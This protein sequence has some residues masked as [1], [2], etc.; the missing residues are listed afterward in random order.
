MDKEL[1]RVVII[2][3][4]VLVII[5]ML[6]WHFFKSLRERREYDESDETGYARGA[7][8]FED[9]DVDADDEEELFSFTE[10]SVVDGDALL[11][12]ESL[13]PS[14][15]HAEPKPAPVAEKVKAPVHSDLP[16]LIEFSI[17]ARA[18]EGFNGDQLFDAFERVGLKYGSVKVFERIDRNRLVDFA[19]ASMGNPG[20]FPDAGLYDFFCPGI[21]FFMQPRELD[22]PL[23]VFDDF[24]ETIDYLAV[25]LDG[26]VWDH[27]KLP[28][29]AET[30][31]HF[32]QILAQKQA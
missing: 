2:L 13:K 15:H 11:D 30:I 24:I 22:N 16:K 5:V 19:V 21:V 4:G 23:A 18:D 25:D 27:Q 26:V 17:V 7:P 1:L 12:D 3:C 20:T 31:A 32:R 9:E 28:L 6:L 10:G 8:H 29:T 14:M